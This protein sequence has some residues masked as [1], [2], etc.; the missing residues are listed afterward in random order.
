MSN[1]TNVKILTVGAAAGS[2]RDLFSKIN[3]IDAKHGKFDLVLCTGDFFGPLKD[4]GEEYAEDEEVMQLLNESLEA[5]LECFIMQGEHP[6]PPPVIEKFAKTGGQLSK[7]VFL[8]HKS[9]MMTTAHG[10]RIACLGGIYDRNL[11]SVSESVHGFTS[12]FFTSLTVE[13]LLANTMTK[14]APTT[15]SKNKSY[16]SLAAIKAASS[17]SQLVDILLTNTFPTHVTAFSSAALPTPI[18]PPPSLEGEPVS[19]I[20]KRIKPRYHFVAGGGSQTP[21]QFW[22][23]Q[24][25][26]WND[27]EGRVTRFLSLGVFGGPPPSGKKPRQMRPRIHLPIIE[28]PRESNGSFLLTTLERISAGAPSNKTTNGPVERT[29]EAPSWV[30][31]QDLRVF[32]PLHQ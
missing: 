24:P 2:I 30:Q 32:R 18:F 17:S 6:L 26:V 3:A 4:E 22:E 29:R 13:K 16:G 27:E 25:F 15:D 9:G 20:V 28:V 11:Y 19:D 31:V 5:P 10:L 8:L 21:P 12:P 23:R 14:S 1:P 7:N